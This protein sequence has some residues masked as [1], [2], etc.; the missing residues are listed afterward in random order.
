MKKMIVTLHGTSDHQG[1]LSM[2]KPEYV[3]HMDAYRDAV[4]GQIYT[5]PTAIVRSGA[6][7]Y[8]ETADWIRN[9]FNVTGDYAILPDQNKFN[10]LRL[11]Y[12]YAKDKNSLDLELEWLTGEMDKLFEENEGIVMITPSGL[13]N[14]F[15]TKYARMNGFSE[16]GIPHMGLGIREI[17]V[18]DF[19]GKKISII[20]Y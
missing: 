5:A 9:W 20:K 15:P 17:A 16:P 4:L 18:L 8:R 7:V 12:N 3:R 19:E 1:H 13:A 11:D 10:R 6:D 2:V 14:S